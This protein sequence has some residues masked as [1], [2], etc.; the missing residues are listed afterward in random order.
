MHDPEAAPFV[1]CH[2]MIGCIPHDGHGN[3]LAVPDDGDF[4]ADAC[5]E[6]S[7]HKETIESFKSRMH[8]SM[9]FVPLL[10]HHTGVQ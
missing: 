10:F 8:E 1:M 4:C 2:G 3:P 6:H 9:H 5:F 7:H